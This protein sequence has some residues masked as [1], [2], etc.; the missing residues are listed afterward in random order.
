MTDYTLG[1][2]SSRHVGDLLS[3]YLNDTLP[4]S[5]RREVEAHLRECAHC[6]LDLG[7][8]RLTVRAVGRLPLEPVPRSFAISSAAR[9]SAPVTSFLRWS[10]S[11]L[12]A[13]L[14]LFL[15]VG[16]VLPAVAPGTGTR[17]KPFVAPAAVPAQAPAIRAPSS[18]V[19]PSSDV[20]RRAATAQASGSAPATPAPAAPAPPAPAAPAAPAAPS[21]LT[22]AADTSSGAPAGPPGGV[23]ASGPAAAP[24][25]SLAA[26]PTNTPVK[27]LT[28]NAGPRSDVPSNQGPVAVA[29]SAAKSQGAVSTPIISSYPGAT[30][31]ST[32][33][34]PLPAETYPTEAPNGN[35]ATPIASY[36]SPAAAAATPVRTGASAPTTW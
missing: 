27:T 3:E 11:I 26:A 6:S 21:A 1:A 24:A 30:Q 23:A 10:T 34:T 7:T 29:A 31:P 35:P 18:A 16:V 17:P 22:S 19:G 32:I 20:V 9:P 8:L 2:G 33:S 12:A 28:Q 25:S 13:A 36:P 4:E 14:V 15:A 5:E